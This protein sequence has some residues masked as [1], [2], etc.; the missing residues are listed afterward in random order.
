MMQYGMIDEGLQVV[1]AVRERYD[2]YKRN[3]W[4]E[5]ECGS[6]YA[7]SM[8]SYAL[9]NTLSGFSFDMVKGMIGFDPI[10][11]T[12]E[13]FQCFWSLDSGW[14][15]YVQTQTKIELHILYGDLRLKTFGLPKH[16]TSP[17]RSVMIDGQAAAFQEE[18]GR[19]MFSDGVTIQ[20]QKTLVISY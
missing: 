4:N 13:H 9:L 17:I 5:I 19:L 14:G 12:A 2:G 1:E 11:N 7:R 6:N 15:E 20:T 10:I 18:N 8:A 16:I 3:P